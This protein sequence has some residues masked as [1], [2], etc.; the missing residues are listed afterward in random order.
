[1]TGQIRKSRTNSARKL[2]CLLERLARPLKMLTL[3]AGLIA[4]TS[5]TSNAYG[6][7][8]A[9]LVG[10]WN[11]EA[12]Q[13]STGRSRPP[14]SIDRF[15]MVLQPDGTAYGRGVQSG[16]LGSLH[17]QFRARWFV[18]QGGLAMFG[19]QHHAMVREYPS[20]G[21]FAFGTRILS[22]NILGHAAG[23]IPGTQSYAR[24]RRTR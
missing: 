11:C 18:E 17:Y 8:G 10:T 23:E 12:G 3:A 6:T 4:A 20:T 13:Y 15:V 22:A 5:A 9:D 16:A 24:C 7:D 21:R 14:A 1:M 19:R 2:R